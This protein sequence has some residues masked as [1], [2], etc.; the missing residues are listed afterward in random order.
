MGR[1]RKGTGDTR[2]DILRAAGHL[3]AQ[4]GYDGTTLRGV[5]REAKVDSALVFHYFQNKENLFKELVRSRVNPTGIRVRLATR[6]PTELGPLIVGGFVRVWDS[7][8]PES[9]LIIMLRSALTNPIAARL[10]RQLIEEEIVAPSAQRKGGRS[11]R[12]R[13]SLVGSQLLGLA[14]ARYVLR[15]E[16]IA[17]ASPKA[18]SDH[19][20]P[21]LSA[22]LAD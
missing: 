5:A 2:A 17:K 20:G 1:R 8:G 16:P 6:K 3:F 18:L 13:L 11:V 7:A 19:L 15:M 4:S 14:I 9:V 10:L 22:L 12:L 21:A